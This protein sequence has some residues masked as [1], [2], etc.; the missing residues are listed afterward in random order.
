MSTRIRKVSALSDFAPINVTVSCV[1]PKVTLIQAKIR[2]HTGVDA[3]LRLQK[4]GRIACSILFDGHYWYCF[5]HTLKTD[6]HRS[7]QIMLF[8]FIFVIFGLYVFVRQIVNALEWMFACMLPLDLFQ[9][10]IN[11]KQGVAGKDYYG[12]D[13]EAPELTKSGN[14]LHRLWT[15]F[16]DLINGS[17]CAS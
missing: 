14:R 10:I 9:I 5:S 3:G 4:G 15:N 13:S 16:W 8:A 6:I 1:Y 11:T 12:N 2:I 7:T 17:G